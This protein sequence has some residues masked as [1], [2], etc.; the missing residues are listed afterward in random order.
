M[1]FSPRTVDYLRISITDRC[2]ERCLYCLPEGFKAWKPRE[3][4]LSFEEL[5]RVVEVATKMGF[6]KFRITGGEPLV[7]EGVPEFV[8]EMKRIPGVASIHLTTNG[9]RL[10][11][12]AH[13]LKQAGLTSLNISLDA[14]TP[15]VYR[16]ITHGKVNEVLQG[17]DAA[18]DAGFQRIKLNTVLI[19]GMNDGEIWPILDYA[20]QRQLIVRFI[21]LMPVSLTQ[22]LN[23]TN[24]FPIGELL[25]MLSKNDQLVPLADQFGIG[26]AKYYR[27]INHGAVIGCIGAIT[28]LHFCEGCNKIRLTADGKIRPCLGNHGEHDLKPAL[29]VMKSKEAVEAT[30]AQ[31]IHEK[32]PEHLFRENYQPSRI[33]TAIGG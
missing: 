21:E 19:R 16:R 8:R 22:V 30:I 10:A 28:N 26:P 6:R 1:P 4:I 23:E 7:R 17:I 31:A 29:R 12:I 15:E 13:L 5:L 2:N 9:T 27:L 18:I 24:F 14:L 33:M 11:P 3:E 32:P 20:R 25:Q